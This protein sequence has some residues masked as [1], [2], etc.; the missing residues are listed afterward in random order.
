MKDKT[1]ILLFIKLPPP[2]TGA[3][4]IN[5]YV[6]NSKLLN[7]KYNIQTISISFKKTIEDVRIISFKKIIIVINLYLK[8]FISLIRFKPK[9]IYFQISP[10]G[11]AFY[12]DF[13]Y[14]LII[15]LFR[16]H[17]VF[18][19]H[20]K[21][22]KDACENSYFK[23][24]IYK[25]AFR[26]SSIV[27]LS[28]MLANDINQVYAG[29]P[30]IVNNGIPIFSDILEC[31]FHDEKNKIEVLFLSNLLYSKG[32]L[33][34][35]DALSVL[36]TSS[37]EKIQVKI[38]GNEAEISSTM[39]NKEI[40]KRG[41]QNFVVYIGPKYGE[42]KLN[43]YH[44]TD[45]LIYPTLNDAFPVVILEAMQFG[46]PVIASIEGAIPDIIED[47][48]NGFLVEKNKP[49]QITS[50][51]IQLI[52]NPDLRIDMGKN[53]KTKFLNNYTLEIFERNIQSVF[54][55]VFAKL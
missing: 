41:L 54:E 19:L 35:L 46:I 23:K 40:K 55:S 28:N 16:K 14:V 21:G 52:D 4:L 47:G 15:K 34:F 8:L 6:N 1:R 3:T 9:L 11:W 5:S 43:I 53:G 50:K 25:F 26:G 20:G 22:I 29:T 32:I 42:E 39:L 27:C 45:I 13:I 38:V 51:L 33:V 44:N 17:I 30:Y 37:R 48:I 12:R 10:I 18:H 24:L 49:E 7:D 31:A 2:L 36:D